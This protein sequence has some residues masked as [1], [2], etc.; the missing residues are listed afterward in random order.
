MWRT[1]VEPLLIDLGNDFYIVKLFGREEYERA[2]MEGRWMIGDNYL[3]VQRWR[4]NFFV[5]EVK[6]STL[7]IWVRF[8]DLSVECFDEEWI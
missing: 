8:L 2:M 7:Q 6:I 3:H 5:E 1:S 4:P